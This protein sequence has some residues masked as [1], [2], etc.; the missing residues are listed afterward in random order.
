MK[1]TDLQ[2]FLAAETDLFSQLAAPLTEEQF[3]NQPNGRWSVG[4]TV[5]H[6]YLSA[7]PVLRLM[8][9][10]REVFA[11]WGE[12]EGSARSYEELAQTYKQVLGKG[13]KAPASFS[14]RP[15][16]VPAD[17][18]TVLARLSDTYLE[19]ANQLTGWSE[20]ELDRYQMP[21]PAL[22]LISVR[23]MLYFIGVHT[24]HHIAVLEAY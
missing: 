20:A 8:G 2:A 9:G 4:D 17:K 12:A 10:P 1:I 19:M 7:R 15:A 3:V 22:G 18:A 11:Q 14:P 5:Q 24:R 16:D 13:L 21:H 23:E 6:L